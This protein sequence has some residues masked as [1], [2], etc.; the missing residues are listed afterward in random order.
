MKNQRVK[1]I[2]SFLLTAVG[3]TVLLGVVTVESTEL[4][5]GE[6]AKHYH[7]LWQAAIIFIICMGGT[8]F[9][10]RNRWQNRYPDFYYAVVWVLIG[11]GGVEAV[12]GLRQLYGFTVSN[13]SLY[14]MTGSFFNP[15]PYSGY[16]AMVFPLCLHEWLFF[17][18]KKQLSWFEVLRKYIS[19]A[20]MLMILCLLPAGMSRSAWIAAFVSGVWIY[21]MHAG[22]GAK[23]GQMWKTRR[24]LVSGVGLI[25]LIGVLTIGIVLFHLKKDSASGRLL[26]WKVSCYAITEKP[27]TGYG[28]GNFAK[29][30][31]AAQEDYFAQGGYS[32]QEELVAGSPEYAFNEYLQIVVEWGVPMLVTIL[33]LLGYCLFCG[34]RTGR[35]GVCGAIVSLMVFAFSSYP[36]QLPAFTIAL[37]GLLLA[38][39]AGQSRKWTV[40]LIL[41]G[42][43]VGVYGW[44]A[45]VYK[46]CKDWGNARMLY[47]T[48]VYTDA[49]ERY[50]SLYPALKQRGNFL[51]EYGHCL[52]KMKQYA[53]STQILREAM[54]R[55]CDPMVLNIIG[56]NCQEQGKYAEAERWLLRSTHLLPGRIYPYY[57]LAKLYV[58]PDF[59]QPDKLKAVAEVVMVKEPKVQSTAIKEM[60]DEI[61]KLI[62]EIRL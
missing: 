30:Y 7:Y 5:G 19:L 3:V 25:A 45:D 17:R 51:F 13:H 38:C 10:N 41:L 35:W 21:G 27:L 49:S 32:L 40:A 33:L 1:E 42:G 2:I 60:R 8:L 54:A 31:G 18:R 4:P 44:K 52:H 37:G 34:V 50:E 26:M 12:Y 59:Y 58:E 47:R 15:G 53:S 55:T 29:A 6:I 39:I 48:G 23:L 36:M 14:S 62:K 57:L 46:E 9:F 20:V 11:Y 56:K 28:H 43:V 61:K 24:K 16:L 22:W